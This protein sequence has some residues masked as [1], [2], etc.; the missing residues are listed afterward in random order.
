MTPEENQPKLP[1]P[2]TPEFPTEPSKEQIPVEAEPKGSDFDFDRM[3]KDV[4]EFREKIK[5]INP[6]INSD[7]PDE[8]NDFS[9]GYTPLRRRRR[10]I[11]SNDSTQQRDIGD[12]LSS[13][14]ERS[15]PNLDFFLLSILCGLIIS[16]GYAID[17]NAILMFGIFVSPFLG[18]WVGA[19]LSST[20]GELRY[21]KQTIGGFFTSI[22]MALIASVLVGGVSRF[23][24]SNNHIHAYYHSHLWWPDILLMVVGTIILI[25]RFVQSDVRPIIPSLM[26]SYA[27]YLPVSVAGFG[28]GAGIDGLWPA[29]LFVFFVHLAISLLISLVMFFYLGVR[30][31]SVNGF[32]I[33]G[34]LILVSII[35]LVLFGGFGGKIQGNTSANVAAVLPET[36][37]V[38]VPSETPFATKT[39]API[40]SNTP[41]IATFT[42]TVVLPTLTPINTGVPAS[43]IG[44]IMSME[45]NGVVVRISPGGVAVTTVLNNYPVRILSDP[46]VI[47]ENGE[48][49]HVIIIDQLKEIEGWILSKYIITA[50]PDFA[51]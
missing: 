30:P 32:A 8:F 28:L 16:I 5:S 26:V 45:S 35:I 25:L 46:P 19:L 14:L 48:W 11:R 37:T 51:P 34:G 43:V 31:N 42:A 24:A 33:T 4:E 29:G 39:A 2:N 41:I 27:F 9:A 1:E 21:F 40:A 36:P 20:I 6:D 44:K 7:Q 13:I 38:V 49:V 17:S 12:Q 47:D 23:F 50:T 10:A 3:D 15:T 18:P 22:L